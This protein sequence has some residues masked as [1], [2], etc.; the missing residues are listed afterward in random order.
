M[1]ESNLVIPYINHEGIAYRPYSMQ[2]KSAA[3]QLDDAA[4]RSGLNV[5]GITPLDHSRALYAVAV[6]NAAGNE[7]WMLVRVTEQYAPTP[8]NGN[9][10][11]PSKV[12]SAV[13]KAFGM[14]QK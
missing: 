14:L 12:H 3:K 10:P 6:S 8:Q 11:E 9:G 7:L 5:I 4:S 2:T 13:T 1:M